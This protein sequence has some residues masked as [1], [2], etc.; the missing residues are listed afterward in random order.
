ML[1]LQI[2]LIWSLIG[3]LYVCRTKAPGDP[4]GVILRLFLAGPV[5]WVLAVIFAAMLKIQ[6]RLE[7]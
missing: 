6:K 2:A 4:E 7:E 5:F 3:V 1:I